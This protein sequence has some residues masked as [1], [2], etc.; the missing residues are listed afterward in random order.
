MLVLRLSLGD[1]GPWHV[2]PLRLRK[3]RLNLDPASAI[4]FGFSVTPLSMLS[5]TCVP[6]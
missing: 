3:D 1:P 2:F 4:D 6:G 5:K